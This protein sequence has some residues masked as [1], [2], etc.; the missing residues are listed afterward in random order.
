ME[1]T[2][3]ILVVDDHR[4]IRDLLAR[5]LTRAG[6]RVSVANGGTE[7]RR[8]M[9]AAAIDL[10]VLDIMMPGEDGLTLCRQLR[11]TSDVPVILLTAVSEDTDRIVGLELGADDYV[12]KPFNPRELLARIRAILRRAAA[13]RS[14]QNRRRRPATASIDGRWTRRA[15]SSSTRGARR[16]RSA[17]R[18]P[19]LMAFVER[20]GRVLTRD[21]LLDIPPGGR[22]KPS[23]AAS[24]IW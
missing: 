18:V 21:Q 5:Y 19:L 16:P 15:G 11:Q 7:M 10:V 3:H 24:T 13:R 22:R 20:P 1:K 12:T 8:E 17:R 4:E 2:P 14:P 9:R 23:T 6:L